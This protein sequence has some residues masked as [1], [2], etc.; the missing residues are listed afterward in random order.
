MWGTFGIYNAPLK[1]YCNARHQYSRSALP[2]EQQQHEHG[3]VKLD[4]RHCQQRQG[5]PHGL[6]QG[7]NVTLSNVLTIKV[8]RVVI[9]LAS[10]VKP[11]H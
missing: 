8:G 5:V 9:L 3:G 7:P 2:E 6:H 10:P 1:Q 4:P 11:I